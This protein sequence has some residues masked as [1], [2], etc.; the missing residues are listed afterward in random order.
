ME[1]GNWWSLLYEKQIDQNPQN[2][3][4]ESQFSPDG[5][6]FYTMTQYGSFIRIWYNLCINSLC[7]PISITLM[8]PRSLYSVIWSPLYKNHI[9]NKLIPNS[10]LTYC[11]DNKIRIFVETDFYESFK[12]VLSY[13]LEYIPS[14][15][16]IASL[17]FI[18]LY[19]PEQKKEII[20]TKTN[21]KNENNDN[22]SK[23]ILYMRKQ[24]ES[25]YWFYQGHYHTSREKHNLHH[26]GSVVNRL[27]SRQYLICQ[28]ISS[29][30]YIYIYIYSIIYSY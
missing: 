25:E 12:F 10:L 30:V 15:S 26:I 27:D 21:N 11:R 6:L 7:N 28:T 2:P 29:Q 20:L 9:T 13:T 5:R 18:N 1:W 8:H 24:N 19:V 23:N 16:K 22:Y 14:P 4:L 3:I 17:S